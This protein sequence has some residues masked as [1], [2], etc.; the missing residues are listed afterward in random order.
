MDETLG[1]CE[2]LQDLA[3]H[4]DLLRLKLHHLVRM[5]CWMR[6]PDSPTVAPVRPIVMLRHCISSACAHINSNYAKRHELSL[7]HSSIIIYTWTNDIYS[8]CH[9][10]AAPA[11]VSI[12][13]CFVSCSSMP[14]GPARG[15]LQPKIGT[16]QHLIQPCPCRYALNQATPPPP[17]NPPR[18]DSKHITV[19]PTV[20]LEIVYSPE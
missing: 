15:H 12:Y 2:P 5:V 4:Y 13:S 8:P 1:I 9:R 19:P 3:Q 14:C 17:S 7:Q 18:F 11:S 10:P 6:I 16:L 20:S